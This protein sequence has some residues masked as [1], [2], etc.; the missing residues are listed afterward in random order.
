MRVLVAYGSKLG[1]TSAIAEAIGTTLRGHGFV[2][3]CMQA[4][5]V[6]DLAPYDAVVLGGA[7]YAHRWTRE[8]RTFALH[9]Q[10]ALRTKPTWLFSSGPLDGSATKKE[11]PPVPGVAAVM[12][13]IGARGH[14]TFGGRLAPDAHGFPASAMAKSHSGDWRDWQQIADWAERVARDLEASPVVIAPPPERPRRWLLATL[15]LATA[16][17]AILGGLALVIAPDGSLLHIP[18]SML[19]RSPFASYLVPGLLLAGVVGLINVRAGIAALR[20]APNANALAFV[21]GMG[22]L[23]WM[24]TQMLMLPAMAWLQFV[25]L[26]IAIVIV[27]EALR[28]HARD[29][30]ARALHSPQAC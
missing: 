4:G 8:A 17:P 20:D 7:L 6:R 5:M 10:S 26:A 19:A 3:D 14:T 18:E 25:Y 23:I 13:R 15:C 16:V 24:I 9:F 11:I 12:T 1:G 28:R 30:S 21:G 2:A 22:L 29:L 27:I